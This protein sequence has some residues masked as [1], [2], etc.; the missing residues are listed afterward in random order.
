M[1]SNLPLGLPA[2][3]YWWRGDGWAEIAW[4]VWA[5]FL[6][7]GG[8]QR[9]LPAVPPGD[10]HFVVAITATDGTIA[11]VIPHR[12]R[13]GGGGRPSESSRGLS[14][15]EEAEFRQLS[16]GFYAAADSTLS[17]QQVGRFEALREIVYAAALPP[18]DACVALPAALNARYCEDDVGVRHFLH[19]IA[20]KVS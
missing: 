14:A 20:L 9:P 2:K 3:I 5:A 4:E 17:D 19:A 16:K 1:T 11:N 10:H 6:S 15:S 13:I 8:E 12:Y 18:Y 7:P